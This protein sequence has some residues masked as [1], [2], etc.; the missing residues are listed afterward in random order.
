[1]ILSHLI[2]F[3]LF[4]YHFISIL[5]RN[6]DY[7]FEF[8]MVCTQ[9]IHVCFQS[10][11]HSRTF[12]VQFKSSI[13]FFSHSITLSHSLIFFFKIVFMLCSSDMSVFSFI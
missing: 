7:K 11:F 1:M 13:L 8:D 10:S 9:D 3:K 5:T 12:V 2:L 4:S 6:L